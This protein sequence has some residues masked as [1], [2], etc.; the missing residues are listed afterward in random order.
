[1]LTLDTTLTVNPEALHPTL[2]TLRR[3][4]PNVR[5]C[6][7][8]SGLGGRAGPALVEGGAVERQ[9]KGQLVARRGC[10]AST[11]RGGGSFS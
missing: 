10:A 9:G 6:G 4:E 5:D 2:Y 8:G 1:M 3:G 7:R 11:L